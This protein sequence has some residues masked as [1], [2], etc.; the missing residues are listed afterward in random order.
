MDGRAPCKL[1]SYI[2]DALWPPIKGRK[3]C[4]RQVYEQGKQQDA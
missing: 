2:S 4:Y 3:K 1:L